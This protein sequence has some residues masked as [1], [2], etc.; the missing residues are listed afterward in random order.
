MRF[1]T[2]TITNVIAVTKCVDSESM[3]LVDK[4]FVLGN[5]PDNKVEKEINKQIKGTTLKL[6]RIE[7]VTKEENLYKMTEA[8]FI[9]NAK[10]V[11]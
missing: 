3:E 4:T 5:V 9:A 10:V 7:A 6:V 1:I 2:R 11:E 8:D